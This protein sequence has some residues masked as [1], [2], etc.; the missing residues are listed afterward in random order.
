MIYKR[1][2]KCIDVGIIPS[3]KRCMMCGCLL[4]RESLRTHGWHC[5]LPRS[6]QCRETLPSRATTTFPFDKQERERERKKEVLV[7]MQAILCTF[8]AGMQRKPL[9]NS[10]SVD[11]MC[12]WEVKLKNIYAI[13][14]QCWLF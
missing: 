11:W 9:P 10:V 13:V 1:I 6:P 14:W 5:C 2:N 8:V 3:G 4:S 12:V 7:L